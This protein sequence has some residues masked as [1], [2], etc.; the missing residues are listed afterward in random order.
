MPDSRNKPSLPGDKPRTSLRRLTAWLTLLLIAALAVCAALLASLSL[1]VIQLAEKTDQEMAP[2]LMRSVRFVGNLERLMALGDQLIFVE[3]PKQWQSITLAMQALVSH[4]S[5][6]LNG[7]RPPLLQE[8]YQMADRIRRLR[9]SANTDANKT[10]EARQLWREYRQRLE[11]LS[12][13]TAASTVSNTT[14]L[15]KNIAQSGHSI[16]IAGLLGGLLSIISCIALFWVMKRHLLRPLLTISD[17][18]RAG[19]HNPSV[20]DAM[21]APHSAEIADVTTAVAQL[22]KAHDQLNHMATHD[23]LTGLANRYAL[24]VRLEQAM[25]SCQRHQ[26]RLAL[27][28]IDLDNFKSINDSLGHSVGDQLLCGISQRLQ[29]E[30][31]HSDTVARLGGDEFVILLGDAGTP[32]QVVQIIHKLLKQIQTPLHAGD[33]RLDTSA[34]IGICYY[35]GDGENVETLLQNADIAMYAA[36]EAGRNGYRFFDMEMNRLASE[37]LK[38]E[39]ALRRALEK[40]ELFLHYQPQILTATGEVVAVEALLRWQPEG[41][42]MIPP[43]RFIPVAEETGLIN[44]IG[45]WV[46]AEACH[47]IHAWRQAGVEDVRVAVNISARQMQY[48]LIVLQTRT[49]LDES[50]LPPHLLELE[51]TESVAMSDAQATIE[52]LNAL[53]EQGISLAIDDFGTGYSSLAYL[54]RFP[55]DRLKLDRTFVKDIETDPNDAAICAASI[56]LARSLA[57]EIVA[58]GVE[59]NA[60]LDYLTQL[61]CDLVQGFHFA[62]PLPPD[63]AL[64]YILSHRSNAA[65]QGRSRLHTGS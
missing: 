4:P 22:V 58:E 1:S 47:T 62:R 16:L 12:G 14:S 19:V 15:A 17:A 29:D 49:A 27:C 26:T 11:T 41:E 28:M 55:I 42:A 52:C 51:I 23:Q 59:S 5:M 7:Q 32:T 39:A 54:K 21:P 64:R 33:Y 48:D 8:T 53:K 6:Q 63:D 10:D 61:G 38:L 65:T 60:Q 56:E 50:G 57:L 35:P 44:R 13:N 3:D 36:K 25:N 9:L 45:E 40:N 18:L 30:V 31:R 24:E 20:L 46:L 34:S 2:E 43:D 37:R